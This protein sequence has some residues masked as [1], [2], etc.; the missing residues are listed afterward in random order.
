[1]KKPD[2]GSAF[3]MLPPV[4]PDRYSGWP[5]SPGMSLRDYF[6]GQALTTAFGIWHEGYAGGAGFPLD[7]ENGAQCIAETAYQIADAMIAAREAE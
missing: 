4:E 7:G 2:G 1:M 5:A 3:P 6:A